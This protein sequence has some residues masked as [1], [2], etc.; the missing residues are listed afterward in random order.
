MIS[1]VRSS[2]VSVA[3]QL[4]QQLRYQ[5]AGGRYKTG[6]VLPSTRTLAEQIGV[7]FH[8]VRKAYQQLEREGF[9]KA[10][11]GSGYQVREPVSLSKADRIERGA[12]IVQN[13]L[14]QLISIGLD[15]TEI[16]SIFHEQLDLLGESHE[17]L[18]I[19]FGDE[20]VELAELCA[21]QLGHTLQRDVQGVALDEL[22]L[23]QDADFVFTPATL[24]RTVLGELPRADVRG[25]AVYLGF[26]VLD[27]VARLLPHETLGLITG[28]AGTIPPLIEKLRHQA[29]FD[30]QVMAIS[31]E[32]M[33]LRLSDFIRQ[34]DLLLY[35]PACR[36]RLLNILDEARGH[37]VITPIVSR[38]SLDAI[39]ATVPG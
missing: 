29:G 24:L 6:D 26:D 25:A 12:Q 8:T 10:T 16:E 3:D 19:V 20:S 2:P 11:A 22:S 18:K 33:S 27:R 30:G 21:K 5:I 36:R 4:I 28:N 1:I 34:V 14:Q 17:P 37:S 15:E 38:E 31:I 39:R 32:D 23:H 7:S 9:L 35:T 13:A